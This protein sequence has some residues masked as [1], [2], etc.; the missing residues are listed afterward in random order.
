MNHHLS[1]SW[2]S[3]FWIFTTFDDS[4]DAQIPRTRA[5]LLYLDLEATQEDCTVSDEQQKLHYSFDG[6]ETVTASEVDFR[7]SHR[8]ASW[9]STQ[10]LDGVL[11]S[12]TLY[13]I[14][15]SI[16][17]CSQS[18]GSNATQMHM[19]CSPPNDHASP[20]FPTSFNTH[21]PPFP[22][23]PRPVCHSHSH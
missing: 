6:G 16:S 22:Y 8:Q 20:T 12:V 23:T 15:P 4:P 2:A 10:W 14:L 18:R 5:S 19:Q 11:G 13:D 17:L 9:T 7:A 21:P 3:C 1:F